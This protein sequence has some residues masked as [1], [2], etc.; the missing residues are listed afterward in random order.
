MPG[1]VVPALPSH[2]WPADSACTQ[3]R[4]SNQGMFGR[5]YEG[6][7]AHLTQAQ[8]SFYEY[9]AEKLVAVGLASNE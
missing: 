8:V 4:N 3:Q 2:L 5:R 6:A 9:M 1:V 7:T